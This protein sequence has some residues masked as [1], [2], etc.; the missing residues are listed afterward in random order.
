MNESYRSN[1]Q[2]AVLAG[3]LQSGDSLYCMTP[4]TEDVLQSF[5]LSDD[6]NLL[7]HL[8]V[9][10]PY[11]RL[12]ELTANEFLSNVAY[13]LANLLEKMGYPEDTP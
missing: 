2:A 12:C 11:S 13:E 5:N 4:E 9:N 6:K 8:L 7:V 3:L 1:T 10:E